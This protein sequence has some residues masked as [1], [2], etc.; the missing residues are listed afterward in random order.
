MRGRRWAPVP[1]I[2][3]QWRS[4]ECRGM[5]RSPWWRGDGAAGRGRV[6]IHS[7]RHLRGRIPH[8]LQCGSPAATGYAGLPEHRDRRQ[9][10]EEGLSPIADK[11]EEP[12]ETV[13]GQLA[14]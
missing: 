11:P 12:L 7:R 10:P 14:L 13:R 4:E 8:G 1:Q 2:Q 9:C 3:P 5:F 6:P